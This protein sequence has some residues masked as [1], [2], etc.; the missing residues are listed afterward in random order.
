M[1]M[2]KAKGTRRVG[3][4][5]GETGLLILEAARLAGDSFG[6]QLVAL[7]RG[8]DDQAEAAGSESEAGS[9]AGSDAGAAG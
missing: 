6:D 7:L 3:M 5:G 1:A 8:V 2:I 4:V 9:G